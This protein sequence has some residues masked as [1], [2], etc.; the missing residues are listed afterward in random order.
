MQRRSKSRGGYGLKP[1]MTEHFMKLIV[2]AK[3]SKIKKQL[4]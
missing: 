4:H 1:G 3:D 2:P